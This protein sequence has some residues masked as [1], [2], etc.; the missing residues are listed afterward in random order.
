ML[1]VVSI[2]ALSFSK[3]II[4]NL[5]L[6]YLL[7][8]LKGFM[9]HFSHN[10]DNGLSLFIHFSKRTIETSYF[11][12]TTILQFEVTYSLMERK[13]NCHFQLTIDIF[14]QS[15]PNCKSFDKSLIVLKTKLQFIWQ[16][17]NCALWGTKKSQIENHY[18]LSLCK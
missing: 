4:Q 14:H 17:F 16:K 2:Y 7:C 11:K 1:T 3:R 13:V 6:Q 10:L 8:L 5:I 12:R 15:K 9:H 18:F